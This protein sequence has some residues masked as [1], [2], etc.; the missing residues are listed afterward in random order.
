M[1]EH[2][3]NVPGY[4]KVR[5]TVP[6]GPEA[7]LADKEAWRAREAYPEILGAGGPIF[8]VVREREQGGWEVLP[9]FGSHTPQDARDSMAVHFR[10]TAQELAEAGEA[11]ARA[12]Y[13]A[14]A[15]RLDWE[16]LD[17]LTVHGTR[18]RV[19]RAEQF[20]RM[21]PDGPEPPRR[22]DPAPD[23]RP[24]SRRRARRTP[25]PVDWFVIDADTVTGMSEGLLKMEL[26]SLVHGPGTVPPDVRGD[27]LSAAQTHPGG[28]LL[29]PAFMI[30]ERIDGRWAAESGARATPQ[31]ARESLS[32]DLRVMAPVMRRLDAAERA[33]YA[34]AA[35]RWDADQDVVLDVGGRHLRLVRVERLVRLGADGPEGPRPSDHDPQP[36]V[37]VHTRQLRERGLLADEDDE[38]GEGAAEHAVREPDPDAQELLRLFE[39]ERARQDALEA[40]ADPPPVPAPTTPAPAEPPRHAL[41]DP[42][43]SAEDPAHPAPAGPP[44][45][46]AVPAGDPGPPGEPTEG[47]GHLTDPTGRPT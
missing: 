20:I 17:A 6:A 10:T 12:A 2:G 33:E 30:A 38:D 4:R 39:A 34:R 14:A 21:G 3:E 19:A 26:L 11:A 16:P 23:P 22:S 1:P 35:D 45:R 28:V 36:P 44:G 37:N 32:M 7:A 31:E 9:Y 18:Y 42:A 46:P 29:P 43:T 24:P 8:G 13:L 41:P 40:A 25:D 47:P 5:V 15:E 27:S